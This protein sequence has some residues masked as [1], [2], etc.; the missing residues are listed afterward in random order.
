MHGKLGRSASDFRPSI[1]ALGLLW[2]FVALACGTPREGDASATRGAGTTGSGGQA[3]AVGGTGAGGSGAAAG[4]TGA[5]GH[6]GSSGLDAGGH[7]GATGGAMDAG[8]AARP[9]GAPPSR[10]S[11]TANLPRVQAFDVQRAQR[12]EAMF[13]TVPLARG[14]LPELAV[15]NL[16]ITWGSVVPPATDQDFWAQARKRY[17]MIEAPFDNGGLPLGMRRDGAALTF[18]C[19]LCHTG[20]IAGKTLIGAPNSTVDLESFF[21][22][23]L[24][25]RDLAPVVGIPPP[26]VPFD[27]DG[28][29]S[30]AG[31]H[32]AFGLGFRV[33]GAGNLG[34]NTKFGPQRSPGWWLLHY[35]E[36]IYVDGSA[37]AS[38]HRSMMATLVAF[39]V[40]PDQLMTKE[41][42]FVDIAHYI[43]S[44]ESPCWDMTTLD[45]PKMA[46]GQKVFEANCSRCHVVHN[47]QDAR[48]PNN[49]VT[50]GEVGTDPMRAQRF[51]VQEAAALSASWFGVP[52]FQSTGGYL[53]QPVVGIW[54]R[55][56]YFH[57][58]SVPDLT[59]VLDPTQRPTRWRRAGSGGELSDYDVD[60]VGFRYEEVATPPDPNTREGRL[61][62]DTTREGMSNGGHTF[63]APLTDV[64]RADLLE[65]LRGL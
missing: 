18:D 30:S 51:R 3:G 65:Y 37:Q 35:K 5:G 47:G 40:T 42:S 33:V 62:Y 10:Q 28:F 45:A 6:S 32:D 44:I 4:N 38:G 55:A 57:N 63:G 27:L 8:D 17:G 59:G 48:Y 41:D 24:R 29:T 25:L 21:D 54:A 52:P 12:G 58:G 26:P 20:R 53:A 9:D 56:P 64:E 22:D 14:I 46:R 23:L 11:C 34:L 31:A 1:V 15:R 39:G 13:R 49:V 60:R 36:R 2:G 50:L 19:M 16:W 43:R 61:V 7:A